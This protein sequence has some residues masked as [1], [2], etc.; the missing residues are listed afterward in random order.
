MEY[1]FLQ[2]LNTQRDDWLIK[3]R[4]IR[5]WDAYTAQNEQESIYLEM[6]LLDQKVHIPV[7][8][9]QILQY[10]LKYNETINLCFTK[11]HNY[12]LISHLLFLKKINLSNFTFTK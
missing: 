3:V 1:T 5:L 6:I 9:P 12:S 10:R 2:N 8:L 7:C 11:Q 4:V